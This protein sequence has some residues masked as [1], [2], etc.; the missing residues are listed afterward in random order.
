M[1]IDGKYLLWGLLIKSDNYKKAIYHLWP[2]IIN[3]KITFQEDYIITFILILLTKKYKYLNNFG[4]IHLFHSNSTSK[5]FIYN[6]NYYLNVLFCGNRC[7]I[8]IF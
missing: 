1:F 5:N 4:L 6:K 8:I 7:C 2:I 3:Y